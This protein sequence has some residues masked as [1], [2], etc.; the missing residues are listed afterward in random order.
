MPRASRTGA[1]A[2]LACLLL[3]ATAAAALSAPRIVPGQRIGPVR[4]VA[5]R[6]QVEGAIGPG[7]VIARVP[8]SIAP[9]NRNLD[10]VTVA[11]PAWSVVVRYLTDEASTLVTAVTTRA[12]RYRTPGGVG[13]GSTRAQVRAAHPRA[14]CTAAACRV[15]RALPEAVVTRFALSGDRVTKVALFRLPPAP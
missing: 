11:Y 12:P 8:S 13:V 5:E 7:L 10:E 9:G 3:L 1:L 2:A 14:V 4:I 6:A 15:G